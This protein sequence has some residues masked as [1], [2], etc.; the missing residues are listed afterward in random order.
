M[1]GKMAFI[2]SGCHGLRHTHV[3]TLTKTLRLV[4]L[5]SRTRAEWVYADD[6]AAEEQYHML[7]IQPQRTMLGSSPQSPPSRTLFWPRVPKAVVMGDMADCC[8]LQSSRGQTIKVA[9]LTGLV[10]NWPVD[11]IESL[12]TTDGLTCCRNRAGER[13]DHH[14]RCMDSP[15]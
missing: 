8:T 11:V 7:R 14:Y 10:L 6:H 3:H 12:P 5:V 15:I 2:M 1:I 13:P 4:V 9:L